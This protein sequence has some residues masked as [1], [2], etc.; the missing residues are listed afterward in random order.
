ML[1]YQINFYVPR[2][3]EW[4]CEQCASALRQWFTVGTDARDRKADCWIGWSITQEAEHCPI[5]KAAQ[6]QEED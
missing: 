3:T 2:T 1:L 4:A 5:C 6:P